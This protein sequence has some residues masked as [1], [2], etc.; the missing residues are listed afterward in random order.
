MELSFVL[1]TADLGDCEYVE[2]SHRSCGI[3][4]VRR[5]GEPAYGVAAMVD[6]EGVAATTEGGERYIAS[7]DLTFKGYNISPIVPKTIACR[8]T[9]GGDLAPDPLFGAGQKGV[10]NGAGLNNI[11]LLVRICGLV[12]RVDAAQQY[13]TVR[14]GS[15][16]WNGQAIRDSSGFGG[17][18]VLAAGLS[19]PSAGQYVAVTGALSCEKPGADL[20]PLLRPR[21]QA[22]ITVH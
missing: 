9:G 11:G 6:V 22:D 3:R 20:Y 1:I 7:A 21:T 19:L 8:N 10:K 4:I 17:V 13:F 12:T 14:D 18:R 15:I 5:A 2:P 16:A